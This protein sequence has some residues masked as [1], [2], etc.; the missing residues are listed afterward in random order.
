MLLN[1]DIIS[2][3]TV[4]ACMQHD[5]TIDLQKHHQ[6]TYIS[7]VDLLY[8]NSYIISLLIKYLF[9][10]NFLGLV[11]SYDSFT[12]IAAAFTYLIAFNLSAIFITH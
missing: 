2:L 7:G 10:S 9:P 1:Y 12:S 3:F 8:C 6:M 11:F 4:C 5:G